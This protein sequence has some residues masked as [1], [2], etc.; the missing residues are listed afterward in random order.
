MISLLEYL[1]KSNEKKQVWATGK[2][3]SGGERSKDCILN[4]WV[5]VSAVSGSRERPQVK[6]INADRSSFEN[7]CNNTSQKS[8]I[9]GSS[10]EQEEYSVMLWSNVMSISAQPHTISSICSHEYND[11][12]VMGTIVLR[13]SRTALACLSNSCNRYYTREYMQ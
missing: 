12:N 7:S 10:L 11:S 6:R 9:C 3:A 8:R 5:K 2:Y 1:G 4:R 13:P